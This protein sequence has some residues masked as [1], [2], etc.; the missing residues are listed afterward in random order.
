MGAPRRRPRRG[1]STRTRCT[2]DDLQ[3]LDSRHH[4]LRGD[5]ADDDLELPFRDHA[6][7]A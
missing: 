7:F 3:L 2:G 5:S 1:F 6:E 4:D